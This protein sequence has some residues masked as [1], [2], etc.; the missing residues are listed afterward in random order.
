MALR[1]ATS[2]TT[3]N[4]ALTTPSDGDGQLL[5]YPGTRKEAPRHSLRQSQ[6]G[7]EQVVRLML[8]ELRD[9]GFADSYRL[10][11]NESGYTLEDEP[12]ARFRNNIL[13]GKWA[14][15]ENDLLS[16]GIDSHEQVTAARFIVK[17]Q[18]F[19]EQLE[20]RQLKQAL[21]ILQN[22]LSNLTDD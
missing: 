14:E 1:S 10:L 6:F 15:V 3:D 5:R 22:E 7:E 8:Q 19:L 18:R 17:R 11:Q 4:G 12:V 16:I 21:L 20:A 13:A 2:A 9:R